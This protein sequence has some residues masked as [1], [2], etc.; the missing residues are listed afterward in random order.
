MQAAAS[1]VGDTQKLAIDRADAGDDVADAEGG[2]TGHLAAA[3][4]LVACL[5]RQGGV[6]PATNRS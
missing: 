6:I 3:N 4:W 2:W 1:A 5:I